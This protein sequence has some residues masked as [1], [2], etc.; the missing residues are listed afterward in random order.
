MLNFKTIM[1]A[2]LA[3]LG[4]LALSGAAMAQSKG[5]VGI[6]MPTKSSAR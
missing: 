2:A 5:T 1:A 3:G 4:A 6:A